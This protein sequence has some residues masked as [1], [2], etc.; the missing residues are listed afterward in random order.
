MLLAN[1][2]TIMTFLLF[3]LIFVKSH[4]IPGELMYIDFRNENLPVKLMDAFSVFSNNS[5]N[6]GTL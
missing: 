1:E 5:I 2:V 6:L 4:L 3:S